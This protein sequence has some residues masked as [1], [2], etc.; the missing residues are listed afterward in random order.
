MSFQLKY[1]F[2]LEKCRKTKKLHSLSMTY[3]R[4]FSCGPLN[5]MLKQTFCYIIHRHAVYH[6]KQRKKNIF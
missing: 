2:T 4:E 1:Q 5:Y 6:L 3:L